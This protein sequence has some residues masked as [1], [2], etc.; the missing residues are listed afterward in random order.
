MVQITYINNL[1]KESKA[2]VYNMH[3]FNKQN[4]FDKVIYKSLTFQNNIRTEFIYKNYI[5]AR[6]STLKELEK[7]NYFKGMPHINRQWI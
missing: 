5:V 7:F 6:S 4:L 2:H 3:Y 1:Q